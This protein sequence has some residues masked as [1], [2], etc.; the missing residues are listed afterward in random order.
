MAQTRKK[1]S[2]KNPPF[3]PS[4]IIQCPFQRRF[5]KYSGVVDVEVRVGQDICFEYPDTKTPT[6]SSN[7]IVDHAIDIEVED[8]STL[9]A[10]DEVS[11][12]VI[13]SIENTEV[14]DVVMPILKNPTDDGSSRGSPWRNRTPYLPSA[15]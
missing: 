13:G 7:L 9:I 11:G 10:V 1:V 15:F 12:L 8:D 14:H 5:V 4:I 2:R 6:G 3:N